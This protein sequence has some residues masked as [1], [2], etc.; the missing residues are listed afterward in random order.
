MQD[1]ARAVQLLS[2]LSHSRGKTTSRHERS[3]QLPNASCTNRTSMDDTQ[4]SSK[5]QSY[6]ASARASGLSWTV[7]R[8]QQEQSFLPGSLSHPGCPAAYKASSLGKF[9]AQANFAASAPGPRSTAAFLRA[10]RG[11]ALST[12]R[13]FERGHKR[14]RDERVIN[15]PHPRCSPAA[16]SQ[17]ELFLPPPPQPRAVSFWQPSRQLRPR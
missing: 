16:I 2:Q 13:A 17:R 4:I 15:R 1:R 7:Q 10:L 9:Q 14:T 5:F 12:Q 8:P 3:S 6:S 11:A